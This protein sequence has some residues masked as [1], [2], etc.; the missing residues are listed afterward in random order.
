MKGSRDVFDIQAHRGE[1]ICRFI[2]DLEDREVSHATR[3]YP[4]KLIKIIP[5]VEIKEIVTPFS[6]A[7]I[8]AVITDSQPNVVRI[9]GILCRYTQ[10]RLTVGRERSIGAPRNCYLSKVRAPKRQLPRSIET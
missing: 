6:G 4:I 8:I 1:T 10:S 3:C 5:T 9:I 7:Q 2:V